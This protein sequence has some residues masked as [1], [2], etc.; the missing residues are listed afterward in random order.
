MGRQRSRT[1]VPNTHTKPTATSASSF[2]SGMVRSENLTFEEIYSRE[3]PTAIISLGE[4]L[5]ALQSGDRE[6]EMAELVKGI[7]KLLIV[8]K[9]LGTQMSP[10]FA[11]SLSCPMM[12]SPIDINVLKESLTRD[13]KGRKVAFCCA[14]CPSAWDKL[15]DPQK[16]ARVPGVKL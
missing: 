1:R 15:S 4:A 16:Q 6:T 11:N 2:E 14:G 13:Y 3:F 12:G 10:Q 7:D 5:K 9:A 8:Y